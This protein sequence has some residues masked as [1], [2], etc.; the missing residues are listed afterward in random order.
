MPGP[1]EEFRRPAPVTEYFEG[2]V[3]TDM[4]RLLRATLNTAEIILRA[5]ETETEMVGGS[6]GFF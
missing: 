5:G 4:D 1:R 6:N 2:R 3:G